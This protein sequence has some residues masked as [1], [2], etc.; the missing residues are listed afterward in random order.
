MDFMEVSFSMEGGVG[1]SSGTDVSEALIM[2]SQWGAA[3][4]ACLWLTSYCAHLLVAWGLGI[5]G[6]N[7]E[8]LKGWYISASVFPL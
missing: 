6:L 7:K 2:V 1:D 3:G 5:P 8:F 4:K